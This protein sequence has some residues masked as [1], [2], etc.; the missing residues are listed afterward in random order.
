MR[1]RHAAVVED[2]FFQFSERT[3]TTVLWLRALG[4]HTVL[5]VSERLSGLSCAR[6]LACRL[7][8]VDEA[9]YQ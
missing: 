1:E 6:I 5:R 7:E 8:E 3:S 2:F 4:R 9:S